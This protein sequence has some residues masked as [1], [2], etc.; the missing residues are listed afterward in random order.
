VNDLCFKI[1]LQKKDQ[2]DELLKITED[3]DLNLKKST[4]KKYF[5]SN[6]FLLVI[7]RELDTI[8]IH[9]K[10]NNIVDNKPNNIVDNKLNN[11]I[12][13]KPNN[14]DNKLNNVDDKLKIIDDKLKIINNKLNNEEN[15]EEFMNKN[16]KIEYEENK[17][18][19]NIGH[20]EEENN[21]QIDY[22][23]N[24]NKFFETNKL[25]NINKDKG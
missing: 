15:K 24:V 3:M 7:K 18:D 16:K 12:D 21:F 19:N 13:N 9:S 1:Y 4:N 6:K 23:V 8:D 11:V 10:I 14:V 20:Y 22:S 17:E 25:E 2:I 5:Q